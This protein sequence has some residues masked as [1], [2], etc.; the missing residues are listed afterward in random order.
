M[1]KAF[2]NFVIFKTDTLFNYGVKFK[3][4]G[5]KDLVIDPTFE[6]AR[7]VRIYGEVVSLPFELT[8]FPITQE[9]RGLP[10]YG[11]ESPFR[12]KFL[13][14]IEQ[15]LEIGDRIYFH[16]NTVKQHNFVQVDGVHPDRVWY[17]KVRYD[18]IICAVRKGQ[19]IPIGGYVLVDPDF[20]SWEDISIPTY[21]DLLGEDGKQILKPKSQWLVKKSA[22]QYKYLLG[23]VRHIGSPLRG[24]KC[25]VKQGQKIV[26]K[27]N[28]DW[29][30]RVEDRDYFV[31]KQR[32]IVGRF[33]EE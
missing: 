11:V 7:H 16:F 27:P 6:P 29:T 32:H 23:F 14:D 22:P 18:Q 8:N 30:V 5:G 15:E 26:Y 2:R 28:A 33:E 24:D 31:I 25:E 12:Y 10:S 3:G 13:N 19:I 4:I 9:Y 21:S 20:E 1:I 17:I